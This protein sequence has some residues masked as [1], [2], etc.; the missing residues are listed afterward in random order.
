MITTL[1]HSILYE[2]PMKKLL[3]TL[4]I[5]ASTC[6][7]LYAAE[8]AIPPAPPPVFADTESVTNAPLGAALAKARFL[9]VGVA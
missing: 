1:S 4:A 9:R 8:V 3:P 6:V 2:V 7:A 5:A